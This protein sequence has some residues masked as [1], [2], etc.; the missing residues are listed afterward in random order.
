MERVREET[1]GLTT[2]SELSIRLS[3]GSTELTIGLESRFLESRD[4]KPLEMGSRQT[5]GQM[6]LEVTVRFDGPR[7]HQKTVQGESVT[8]A[9]SPADAGAWLPPAAAARWLH[10]QLISAAESFSFRTVD[11]LLGPRPFTLTHTRLGPA[12]EIELPA[13]RTLATPFRQESDFEGAVPTIVYLDVQGRTVRSE[14][15]LLGLAMVSTL[16]TAA[17]ARTSGDAPE[18]LVRSFIRPDRPL[19]SPRGLQRGVY[20]LSVEG[21]APPS[22]PVSFAQK[23]ELEPEAVKVTVTTS[24]PAP[25]DREA[26]AELNAEPYLRASAYLNFRDAKVEVLRQQALRST[27]EGPRVRAER[28]RSFVRHRLRTK[29]LATG[30]ATASEVADRLSGDCTEHAVLLAALLRGDG[31]PSR[32]VAGLL[33]VEE[34]ASGREIFGYHMWTQAWLDGRWLDLDA[35]LERPFDAAHVALATS[36]LNDAEAL[37]VTSAELLSMM[38]KLRVEVLATEP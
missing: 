35:M 31:I 11:P 4:G 24:G 18:L 32:V 7:V 10:Q 1:A 12:V 29:D 14:A 23:V 30:F 6:P 16:S 38:G 21:A 8:H 17:E 28:L 34:F 2:E 36:D 26:G 22:L 19:R 27:D 25:A 5:M 13:G 3:R 33:Y 20:R 9:D 37:L 15:Q